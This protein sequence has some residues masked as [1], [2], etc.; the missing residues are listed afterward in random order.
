MPFGFGNHRGP[1][2]L[3]WCTCGLNRFVLVMH[4]DLKNAYTVPCPS[5]RA[6]SGCVINPEKA[7]GG[8]CNLAGGLAQAVQIRHRNSRE[9]SPGDTEEALVGTDDEEIV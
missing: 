5:S 1:P 3:G 9:Q 6:R 8:W 2:G 4:S 7:L